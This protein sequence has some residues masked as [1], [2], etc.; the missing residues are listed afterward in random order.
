LGNIL[1][2]ESYVNSIYEV[3]YNQ[4]H[5]WDRT[6]LDNPE[7][8]VVPYSLKYPYGFTVESFLN[9][10][11]RRED[12][13]FIENFLGID[14]D[15]A[16]NYISKAL[17]LLTNNDRLTNWNPPAGKEFQMADVGR[18]CFKYYSQKYYPIIA[19]GRGPEGGFYDGGDRIWLIIREGDRV[20]TVKYCEDTYEGRISMSKAF[21]KDAQMSNEEF[22]KVSAYSS[23]YGR[24]FEV[25]IDVT[26][27]DTEE[28]VLGRIKK[29]IGIE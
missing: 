27:D 5:F 9:Q 14:I 18:I 24:N 17:N 23:P 25:V 16:N 15:T 21:A 28:I 26:D 3:K 1:L 29:Q 4:R 8:R 12:P 7:S 10:N 22:K 19:G 6:S 20:I 2:F 13:D 11:D